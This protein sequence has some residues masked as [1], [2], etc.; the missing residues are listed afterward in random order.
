MFPLRIVHITAS[1]SVGGGPE[2]VWQLLCHLP[3]TLTELYLAAPKTEPYGS[4]F[5]A[6]LSKEHYFELPERRWS[7]NSIHQA[8]FLDSE[9]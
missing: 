1:S 3:D 5:I 7:T 6:K 8:H 9:A 2:H 4:K